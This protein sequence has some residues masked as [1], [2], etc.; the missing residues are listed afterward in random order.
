MSTPGLSV[1]ILS[2]RLLMPLRGYWITWRLEVRRLCCRNSVW[3]RRVF[4]ERLPRVATPWAPCTMRLMARLLAIGLA[5][6]GAAGVRLSE[7]L[8]LTA[9]QKTHL[10][11]IP[12]SPCP[13]TVPPT[14]PQSCVAQPGPR[15][16]VR[17]AVEL[18]L[19]QPQ[20]PTG[21]RSEWQPPAPG[22]AAA[23]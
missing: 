17:S 6:V 14:S 1:V 18:L 22:T 5:L 9:G 20:A 23:T 19:G 12:R 11:V 10:R 3:S 15:C 7:F 8:G 13:V 2:G 21:F 4:T 16:G